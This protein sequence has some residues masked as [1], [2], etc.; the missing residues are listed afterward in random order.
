[1]SF[2]WVKCRSCKKRFKKKYNKNTRYHF[3]NRKCHAIFFSKTKGVSARV[4]QR[5]CVAE[6][7]A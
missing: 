7:A 2:R 3:C 1:M 4:F 5:Y 6:E